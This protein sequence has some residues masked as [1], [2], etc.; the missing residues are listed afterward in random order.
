MR[1]SLPLLSL[2]FWLGPIARA[3]V[4][5]ERIIMPLDASPSSFA[6]GLPDGVNFCYD[7][8]RGA[9]SYAWTGDFIDITSARPGPGGKFITPVKLMGPLFYREDGMVPLRRGD[10]GRVPVYE[11]KGYTLHDTGVEFRYTLDG[12]LVR[13]FVRSR[14]GQL[15]LIRRFIVEGATDAKW[16]YVVD[17]KPATELPASTNGSRLIE[18]NPQPVA[19]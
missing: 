17:G 16:W 4:R 10:P 18:V 5:I 11:F 13:E 12:F 14:A 19:P 7:P 15:G 9:V 3:E 8:V 6:I 2:L 1:I